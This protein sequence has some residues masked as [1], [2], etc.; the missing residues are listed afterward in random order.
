MK[1]I[2]RYVLSIGILLISLSMFSACGDKRT[3]YTYKNE[4]VFA[5]QI[6]RTEVYADKLVITFA[7]DS[8]SGVKGVKCYG[9]DFSVIEEEP[10]FSFKGNALTIETDNADMIS[11][12]RVWESNRDLYF[13][14]RYLNSESYAMLVNAWADDIG[15]MVNGDEDAYYTREEKDERKELEE[16]Q[17]EAEA[18]AYSK[19]VGEWVNESENTRI[20]FDF[21]DQLYRYFTVYI[22]TDGEWAEYDTMY[23]SNLTEQ[24]SGKFTDIIL[25]DNPSWGRAVSFSLLDD[26]SGME[27]SYSDEKFI[28]TE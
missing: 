21:D 8:L 27:C 15:Y 24:D 19:L 3:T 11:G 10:V 1:R 22:L 4:P 25:Y 2:K 6:K 5:I 23:I 16:L 26:E 28:R 13:D 20:T 14:V 9:S 17:A 7:K 12:L 18:F